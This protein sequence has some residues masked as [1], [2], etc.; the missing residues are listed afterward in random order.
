MNENSILQFLT[1]RWNGQTNKNALNC[2]NI[3]ISQ[4]VE[5][6]E[7]AHLSKSWNLRN[8][9]YQYRDNQYK[10]KKKSQRETKKKSNP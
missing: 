3:L 1:E 4:K 8:S 5:T 2:T 10:D 6:Y 7:F 9:L